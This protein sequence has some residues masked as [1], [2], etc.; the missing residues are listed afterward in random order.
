[1][2]LCTTGHLPCCGGGHLEQGGEEQIALLC[3]SNL[4]NYIK[5]QFNWAINKVER[6]CDTE[7][8]LIVHQDNSRNT[9]LSRADEET[10]ED[11]IEV[12]WKK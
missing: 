12:G 4:Y 9:I 8:I 11:E 3:L 2:K 5:K 6:H 7:D 1:M 10:L